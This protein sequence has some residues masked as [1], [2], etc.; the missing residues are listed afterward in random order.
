MPGL[1][2]RALRPRR[3]VPAALALP[4]AAGAGTL[5]GTTSFTAEVGIYG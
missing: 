5:F 1:L 3:R 2:R 4:S